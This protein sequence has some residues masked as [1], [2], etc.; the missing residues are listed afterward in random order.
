[1]LL[2]WMLAATLPFLLANTC[3]KTS[4]APNVITPGEDSTG[5]DRDTIATFQVGASVLP[6]ND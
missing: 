6:E 5:E 2:A 3:F 4:T 1:M